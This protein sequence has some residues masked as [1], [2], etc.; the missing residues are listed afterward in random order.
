MNSLIH[1]LL[2]AAATD[3]DGD[4]VTLTWYHYPLGDSYAEPKDADK[5]P[6]PVE[7]AVSEDGAEASF[8][9]PADAKSGDTLHVILEAIDA[10]GTNP[11]AYQRVIVTVA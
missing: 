5:N 7:L 1:T 3:P 11:R 10:G 6:V 9:V 8:T 4:A 2:Y